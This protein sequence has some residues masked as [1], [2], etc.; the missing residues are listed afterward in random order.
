MKGLYY[1]PYIDWWPPQHL[2]FDILT[3][4]IDIRLD[5]PIL[6]SR[7]TRKVCTIQ[8]REEENEHYHYLN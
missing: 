2:I 7:T 5:T 1:T 8:P 6:R 4:D 3:Y